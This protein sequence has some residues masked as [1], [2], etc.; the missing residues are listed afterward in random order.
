MTFKTKLI[1]NSNLLDIKSELEYL[2]EEIKKFINKQDLLFEIKLIL[3]ELVINSAIHGNEL[4]E[5]KKVRLDLEIDENAMKLEI[6]DEGNGFVYDK[7]V[8]N[9]LE[10]TSNGRGLVIVDGLSDELFIDNNKV[11]VVK[12]L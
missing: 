2:L 11:S 3:N 5:K 10:L 12:Y 1:I 8:Y 9:P 7:N 4:D 6:K